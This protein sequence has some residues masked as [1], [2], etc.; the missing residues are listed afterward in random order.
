MRDLHQLVLRWSH[1]RGEFAAT[2][3]SLPAAEADRWAKILSP[4]ILPAKDR[5]AD[6]V[7]F[8]RIGDEVAL[9][10]RQDYGQRHDRDSVAHVIL[11]PTSEL[12]AWH[13]LAGFAWRGR[14]LEP[15]RIHLW[16]SMEHGDAYRLPFEVLA[17]LEPARAVPVDI[18]HAEAKRVDG[19]IA[20]LLTMLR[21]L[22]RD[23]GPS[24]A[25]VAPRSQYE[26]LLRILLTASQHLEIAADLTFTTV[27]EVF[28]RGG[29][30]PRLYFLEPGQVAKQRSLLGKR[31]TASAV[32]RD[33][34]ARLADP[35]ILARPKAARAPAEAGAQKQSETRAETGGLVTAIADAAAATGQPIDVLIVHAGAPG[36]R[37][38]ADWIAGRLE[39]AKYNVALEEWLPAGSNVVVELDR[40]IVS[41]KQVFVLCS[42]PLRM[43]ES[44]LMSIVGA[45]ARSFPARPAIV[46]IVY[47]DMPLVGYLASR[48]VLDLGAPAGSS[49]EKSE[50]AATLTLLRSAYILF[51][52]ADHDRNLASPT[53]SDDP[54]GESS[55]ADEIQVYIVRGTASASHPNTFNDD[56]VQPLSSRRLAHVDRTARR[57][58]AAA[59]R[60]AE[61]LKR[62]EYAVLVG[63]LTSFGLTPRELD[64]PRVQLIGFLK[65]LQAVSDE[66]LEISLPEIESGTLD[67]DSPNI[68][69]LDLA[70][71]HEGDLLLRELGDELAAG[72]S[73]DGGT[74][75]ETPD[76]PKARRA[77]E[78]RLAATDSL[79]RPPRRAR[80]APARPKSSWRPA[81]W[82]RRISAPRPTV[83]NRSSNRR[84]EAAGQVTHLLAR[85]RHWATII[86]AL[87]PVGGAAFGAWQDS[88][89]AGFAF[90]VVAPFGFALLAGLIALVLSP[91]A[92]GIT[93]AEEIGR[94][95][96]HPRPRK[97]RRNASFVALL[98][99]GFFAL[100]LSPLALGTAIA[101]DFTRAR[102]H[103]RPAAN[104]R[105]AIARYGLPRIRRNDLHR[106]PG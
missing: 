15:F 41:A 14:R 95:V 74:S 8:L 87:L 57:E 19:R 66:Q 80:P 30:R 68:P 101:E 62:R 89:A 103:P 64:D 3:S 51:G 11:G 88:V 42:T 45:R 94:A 38:R 90:V 79:L 67:S 93:I 56:G 4:W 55:D 32:D 98:V 12:T 10:F 31:W 50:E 96:R 6:D 100:V 85:M 69:G 65:N 75:P 2:A 105:R 23:T 52:G 59:R 58:A 27:P 83:T 71:D 102:R 47:D 72:V 35:R 97:A 39:A 22:D 1:E 84:S 99:T 82:A 46:P 61:N 53:I 16:D 77:I 44:G 73:D 76:Q 104:R 43:A 9:C 37:H 63:I 48:R 18:F 78:A 24:F 106:K 34:I 86:T 20:P 40:A 5:G 54:I 36:D 81:G 33:E 49:R 7:S 28:S 25:V 26:Y 17:D 29:L 91:L 21:Y 13:S 92:L 70:L 60:L